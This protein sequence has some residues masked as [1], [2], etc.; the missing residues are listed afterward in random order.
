MAVNAVETADM[1]LSSERSFPFRA[2][3]VSVD[4]GIQAGL[5]AE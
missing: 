2:A 4:S 1:A 3:Q 5:T